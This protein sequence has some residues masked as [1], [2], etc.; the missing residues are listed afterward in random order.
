MNGILSRVRLTYYYP[1]LFALF[2]LIIL[3]TEKITMTGGPLTLFS[4][5]SFLLAF[6]LGPILAGQKQRID[7]LSR[8]VRAEAIALVG[9][10]IHDRELSEAHRAEIHKRIRQYLSACAHAHQPGEGEREYERLLNYCLEIEGKDE[11]KAKKV[12]EALIANQQNRGM[13]STLM[14]AAVYSHEWVVLI[15][16]FSIT[17][18][19][20]ALIDYGGSILLTLVAALLCAGLTLL[21]LILQKLNSLSHKRARQIWTP[22][23]RLLATNLK[24]ID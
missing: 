3:N 14:R 19:Y 7:D 17:I 15:A 23:D 13:I 11:E 21:F 8:T 5:N 10:T 9:V 6:Y 22:F 2:L 4:V 24:Q 12:I 1:V 20:I 18:S 16:L